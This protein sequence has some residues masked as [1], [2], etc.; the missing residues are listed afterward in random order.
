V[1]GRPLNQHH[2][3]FIER[4]VATK[5]WLLAKPIWLLI[6]R[7]LAH[8]RKELVLLGRLTV[9]QEEIT[10]LAKAGASCTA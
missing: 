5:T 7:E 6:Q 2:R 9:L 4:R 1:E 3:S 8:A 10:W